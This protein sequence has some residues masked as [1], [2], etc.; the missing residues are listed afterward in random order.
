MQKV[1]SRPQGS[2]LVDVETEKVQANGADIEMHVSHSIQN[3]IVKR[4]WMPKVVQS[5]VDMPVAN[6]K[7]N[8]V[9]ANLFRKYVDSF[10]RF[11]FNKPIFNFSNQIRCCDLE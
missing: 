3:D 10:G 9:Q 1:V 7:L 2:F 11:T 8:R 5:C 6:V 4:K